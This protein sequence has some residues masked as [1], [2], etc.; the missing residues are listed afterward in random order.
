MIAD[1]ASAACPCLRTAFGISAERAVVDVLRREGGGDK[2][3][4][5]GENRELHLAK[6]NLN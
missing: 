5:K 3:G 1:P 4:T 6:C 2:V